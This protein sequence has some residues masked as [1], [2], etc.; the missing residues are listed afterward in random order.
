MTNSNNSI[1]LRDL[2]R[3]TRD[4]LLTKDHGPSQQQYS[5]I[6]AHDTHNPM[7]NPFLLTVALTAALTAFHFGYAITSINV[8]STIFLTCSLSTLSPTILG[9]KGCFRV[10]RAAWG[11]VGMGLPL[12]GWIGSTLAPTLIT[13]LKGSTKSSILFLNFPLFIAYLLMAFATN[14]TMLVIGRCLL[15]FS[16]GA[17]GMI[18][19]LYLSSISPLKYRGLFTNFFQLFLCSGLFIAEIVSYIADLGTQLWRWRFG[20]GGCLLIVFLQILLS[21]FGF[22][23]QSP[24]DLESTEA[25]IL[26]KKLGF[27]DLEIEVNSEFEAKSSETDTP[28]NTSSLDHSHSHGHSRTLNISKD[29]LDAIPINETITMVNPSQS[30]W[31]LITFK[32][33]Q[34]RKSLALGILLHIGQQISGVNAIFFYSV[35]IIGDSPT[36]PLILAFINLVMTLVAIWLLQKFGRRP[37]ALFSIAGSAVSLLALA[38]AFIAFP[39][40][41]PV[42]LISFVACFS[43]G[44]GPIPWML[45]PELFPPAWSLTPAAISICVSANWI[46]NIII[47][48]VFPLLAN[49][50]KQEVI[51]M[52]F[53]ASCTILLIL[54]SQWLPETKNRSAN[55]I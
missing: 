4:Q 1:E 35:M 51:F 33:P 39:A 44:L 12:G 38:A 34:S 28:I 19:P 18:I 45:V 27:S 10:S 25:S 40:V 15:G 32:I 23:P 24:R 11:L 9:L 31:E 3:S 26:R 16:A 17:S 20:F 30:L 55:F 52:V 5:P 29:N 50:L 8:P 2:S 13:R 14:L 21:A 53:G 42:F 46:T 48:G 22:L 36:T 7:P 54:I 6:N 43:I 37:V 41:A 49:I 47:A